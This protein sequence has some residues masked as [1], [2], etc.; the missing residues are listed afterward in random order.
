LIEAANDPSTRLYVSSQILCEFYSIIT[1]P[2]RV[3]AACSA[4]E[5]LTIIAA[6]LALPGIQVLPTPASVV[7]GWM[8]LLERR[9]VTGGDVFDLQ[10]VATMQGSGIQRIYTFN[11]NDFEVFSELT[12]LVP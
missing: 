12:V 2:R 9:P 11:Q 6:I 3:A 5:A 1:N 7:A 10:I 4:L 8:Q